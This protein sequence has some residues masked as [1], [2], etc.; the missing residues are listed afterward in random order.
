MQLVLYNDHI[1]PFLVY[2]GIHFFK[3][4]SVSSGQ[5]TIKQSNHLIEVKKQQYKDEH[6]KGLKIDIPCLYFVFDNIYS[7]YCVGFYIFHNA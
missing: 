2:K 1:E 7:L 6:I 5:S 4:V 3:N